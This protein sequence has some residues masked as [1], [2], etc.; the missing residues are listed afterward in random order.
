MT[1]RPREERPN[2]VVRCGERL[3]LPVVPI[4]RAAVVAEEGGVPEYIA[5][6]AHMH[7]VAEVTQGRAD[8]V[9]REV[10]F[11]APLAVGV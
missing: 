1:D 9:Q 7:G 2:L 11:K 10:T 4:G 5:A 6:S 3:C 8:H